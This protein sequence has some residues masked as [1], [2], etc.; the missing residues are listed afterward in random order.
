MRTLVA[1][2]GLLWTLSSA[3]AHPELLEATPRDGSIVASSPPEVRLTFTE[4]I[5]PRLSGVEITDASGKR[6][7]AGRL[8]VQGSQA[9]IALPDALSPGRY[10]VNWHAIS[11]DTHRAQGTITF[12][13]QP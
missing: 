10:R 7:N 3:L 12:E 11:V 6:V 9:V 1:G 13:V 8:Q 2:L 5:E 4:R